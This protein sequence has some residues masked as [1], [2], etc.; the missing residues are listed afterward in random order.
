MLNILK[1]LLNK[2][3]P[4]KSNVI[5]V[6]PHWKVSSISEYWGADNQIHR[7]I[8]Y[9]MTDENGEQF[10][11]CT[12]PNDSYTQDQLKQRARRKAYYMKLWL[13]HRGYDI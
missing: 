12:T 8:W 5:T 10:I 9:Q 3:D 4:V 6:K 1:K 2:V 13:R 7:T 11:N